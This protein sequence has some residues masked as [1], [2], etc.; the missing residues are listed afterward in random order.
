MRK[1][2]LDRL[3]GM[4]IARA[5]TD[6]RPA[7]YQRH[8]GYLEWQEASRIAT[9]ISVDTILDRVEA[10][11]RQCT[12]YEAEFGTND[13]PTVAV[14]NAEDHETI[15][16]R[17]TAVSDWQSVIRDLRLYELAHQLAQNAG[18]LIPA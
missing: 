16:D 12:E 4:G 1:K 2:H 7:R 15:H 10:L 3:A 14:F 13:L 9:D 5:D 17:M 6:C 18:H 11:E 8:D